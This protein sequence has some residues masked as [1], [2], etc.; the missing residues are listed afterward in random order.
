[1]RLP[2]ITAIAYMNHTGG[3]VAAGH[4]LTAEA[5]AN[6]LREGGNAFDAVLAALTSACVVEPVLASLG[7]GGFLLAR[8]KDEK[9]RI[10]DFFVQTPKRCRSE[11]ETD[12]HPVLVD[13]GTATQEFHIG[14]GAVAIPGLVRGLFEVHEDLCTVPMSEV[15]AQAVAYA[16]Q[17]VKITAFQAY[18]FDI[19]SNIYMAT[20]SSAAIYGSRQRDGHA[21]VEDETLHQPELADVM[22]VLAHEGAELFY[23]GEIAARL[24]ADMGDGGHL[25]QSD[26]DAYTVERR[27]PFESAYADARFFTNP[28][29]SSGGVLIAFALELLRK[30][31]PDRMQFGS[32]EHVALL[33]KVMD[34][35]SQARLDAQRDAGTTH[36]D[37]RRLLD[38][39]FIAPYLAELSGHPKARSG[40]THISVIDAAGNIAS[41]SV[42]NGE[43]SAYVIPGTGV[44]LNNMLGEEDLHPDGFHR[45]PVDVRMTSMMA[46]TIVQH[47]DGRVIATG[48]GGSNRLRTAILQVLVN[49]LDFGM[50]V[51]TAVT[52]PRIHFEN[53]MLSVEGGF[54]HKRI[55]AALKHFAQHQL[56]DEMNLFFGGAH[57]V[58]TMNKDFFGSGD[59][60]RNGVCVLV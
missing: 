34:L 53:G 49:L 60:R 35:T 58:M 16:K 38:P 24:V 23:R 59:P 13:F 26:L 57:T 44:T 7:G 30:Q 22:E 29:P 50:D 9:P 54:D 51:E 47:A 45:W 14:R 17:G 42:S 18:V 52:S 27:R 10:Y 55:E 5:A 46:P 15:V 8:P 1:M 41:L 20:P 28:P 12:F 11:K 19:L 6:V 4:Q 37:E 2:T 48:S 36:L 33:G 56:W 25:A 40:T 39:S 32:A 31:R 43:G 3:V 21:V